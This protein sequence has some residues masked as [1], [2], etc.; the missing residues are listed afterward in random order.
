MVYNR[1]NTQA[2]NCEGRCVS[3]RVQICFR[4]RINI[5]RVRDGYFELAPGNLGE[6]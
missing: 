5:F 4:E 2:S 3:R 1:A 6:T